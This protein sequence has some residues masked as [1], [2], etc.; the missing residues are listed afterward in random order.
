MDLEQFFAHHSDESME[1]VDIVW[2]WVPAGTYGYWQRDPHHEAMKVLR[3]A[4]M[5]AP[6][7]T[8]ELP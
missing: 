3:D 5:L 1:P 2:E 7:I 6:V 4:G 8:E